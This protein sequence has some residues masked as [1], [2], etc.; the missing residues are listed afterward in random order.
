MEEKE[1]MK[2]LAKTTIKILITPI[3]TI[4]LLIAKYTYL[5]TKWEKI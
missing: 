3:I 2:K 5:F 4:I 1:E